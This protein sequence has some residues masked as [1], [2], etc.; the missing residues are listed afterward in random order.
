[1]ARPR[2]EINFEQFE[3]LC[4]IQCTLD[5]ISYWFKCSSDTVE[6]WCKRELN[7]SFADAYKKYSVGGK[8][9]LRRAQFRMAETNATM[10]IWLGKQY[11]G[12]SDKQ[13]VALS[14][15]DDATIKE[16]EKYFEAKQAKCS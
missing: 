16:M 3:R 5:E 10:A 6:R 13:E 15:N 1:M 11:L 8:I 7:S 12:Q 2:I 14:T 4:Y 9:S